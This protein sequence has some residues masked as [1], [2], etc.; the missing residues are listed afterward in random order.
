[1]PA[2]TDFPFMMQ[3]SFFAHRALL[4]DT[5]WL[6]RLTLKVDSLSRDEIKKFRRWYSFYWEMMEAHHSAEDDLLFHEIEKRLRHP[7]ETIEALEVEHNR[8]Q[9]LIDEIKRLLGEAERAEKI[10]RSLKDQL[11]GHSGELLR[12]FTIHIAGEEKY[13]TENIMRLFTAEEQLQLA[14]KV[15]R[16]APTH[17]LSQLI[18]WLTESL[19]QEE[20]EQLTHSLPWT[21]R[22]INYF[23]WNERYHRMA[24]PVKELLKRA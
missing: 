6:H 22:V 15:K 9:F 7:S 14:E 5:Q 21:A 1:M 17:Y 13:V 19:T 3:G 23:F 12:L 11:T 20:K 8:L 10:M 24:V 2:T 4:R 18:P 16:K